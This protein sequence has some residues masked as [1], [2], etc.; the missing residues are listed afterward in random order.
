MGRVKIPRHEERFSRIAWTGA[1]LVAALVCYNTF[2]AGPVS[3]RQG[4]DDL[5][6]RVAALEAGQKAILKELQEIKALLQAR[7]PTPAQP[8]GAAAQPRP[9]ALPTFDLEIAG[10]PAKGRADAKLVLVEFSDFQC[11]YCG[12]YTRDTLHQLEKEYVE[13][14]KV[15]YVFRHFPLERLHP[16]ALRAAHASE[17]AN[18]Q[19]RFW[20][21]HN[22]LFAN[23][24]ALAE[25]DLLKTAQDLGLN[26]GS[27][28][29]C[30]ADQPTSPPKV[31]KDQ[32]E[33][34]RAGIS[35][36]PTIFLGT[37]TKEGRVK[38][39]R[40]LVGAQPYPNFKK[41]IDDTLA[42]IGAAG[43]TP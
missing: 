17:C 31:R 16:L 7:P 6:K 19:G 9:P 18:A 26:M 38:V 11:P 4:A 34:A 36:T 39:L 41:A 12:R 35:G 10:S 37:L 24:Q 13:T 25:A 23:Q 2:L 40:R 33:G 30:L 1:A 5:Q 28:K 22:R 20:E 42:S 29:S 14:G 32:A 43:G 3:A 21:M 8:A 15:R 27:F